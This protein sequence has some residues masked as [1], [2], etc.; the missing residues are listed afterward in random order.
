M[1]ADTSKYEK[2]IST[3]NYHYGLKL[4][5]AKMYQKSRQIL[6][7]GLENALVIQNGKSYGT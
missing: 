1:A 7:K 3:A 6:E 4:F 5:Q 2:T